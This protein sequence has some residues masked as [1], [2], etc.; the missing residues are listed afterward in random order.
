MESG[1]AVELIATQAELS[2]LVAELRRGRDGAGLR[3]ASGW[4]RELV[5]NELVELVAGRLRL[6]VGPDGR[7][8]VTTPAEA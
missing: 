4:R 6:G 3:V 7:L 5:G 1:V 8:A 2:S